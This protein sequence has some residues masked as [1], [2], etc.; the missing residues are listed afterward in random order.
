MEYYIIDLPMRLS[1]R[2]ENLSQT[3]VFMPSRLPPWPIRICICLA[4]QN[5]ALRSHPMAKFPLFLI[6]NIS[7]LSR[8][9]LLRSRNQSVSTIS[10]IREPETG[11]STPIST[12]R[13]KFRS[14]DSLE[15]LPWSLPLLWSRR[16][17]VQVPVLSILTLP[18][19]FWMMVILIC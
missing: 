8:N 12:P 16:I 6:K 2:T 1:N 18:P 4:I 3:P 15:S 14:L 17:L 10:T 13:Q 11:I 19:L 5:P 9:R 7:N